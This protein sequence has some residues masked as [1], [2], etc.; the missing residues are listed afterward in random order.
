MPRMLIDLAN[1]PEIGLLH[2]R[3]VFGFPNILVIQYLRSFELLH[4]YASNK[5]LAHLSTWR[6]FN[7]QVASNGDVGIWH[8]TYLVK[9]GAHDRL[10]RHRTNRHRRRERQVR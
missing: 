1:R 10:S 2:A 5:S 9:D 7:G 3:T 6:D 4:A 8:E